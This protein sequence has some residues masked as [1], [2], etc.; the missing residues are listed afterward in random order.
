MRKHCNCCSRLAE[1][2][3]QTKT[4]LMQHGE[5][6][7]EFLENTVALIYSTKGISWLDPIDSTRLDSTRSESGKRW[8]VCCSMRPC[9]A[10]R[11]DAPRLLRS[12]VPAGQRANGPNGRALEI[13]RWRS[14][15]RKLR[16][17]RREIG[18]KMEATL[19]HYWHTERTCTGF[20]EECLRPPW[21]IFSSNRAYGLSSSFDT[22]HGSFLG[23]S[24]ALRLGRDSSGSE[25]SFSKTNSTRISDK[26]L[27]FTLYRLID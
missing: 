8:R 25:D 5:E 13:P 2:Q 17:N 3:E 27:R 1:D 16:A 19:R 20:D 12:A 7:L 18:N 23:G 14:P 26:E 4:W 21:R 22:R 10:W 9:E 15:G 11:R 6:F 24:V